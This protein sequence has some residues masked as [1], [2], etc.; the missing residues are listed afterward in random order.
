MKRIAVMLLVAALLTGVA[1]ADIQVY[2]GT[3]Y[4]AF[5][6]DPVPVGVN[7]A[8][9]KLI[10]FDLYFTNKTADVD[11]NP[12]TMD[13]QSDPLFTGITGAL[14]QQEG[15]ILG[16]VSETLSS[17]FAT[18]IDSHFLVLDTDL[19]VTTLPTEDFDVAVSVEPTDVVGPLAPFA[20]LSF[21]SYMGGSFTDT[22]TTGLTTRSLA[23]LVIV[24]PG[25][26][27]VGVAYEAAGPAEFSLVDNFYLMTG[28]GGGEDVQFGIGVI[29]EPATMSLLAIGGVVALIRR[30]K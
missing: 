30:R 14:H 15:P 1:S 12:D 3:T 2:T 25:Q 20:A 6:T 23:H 22:T 27:L 13:D 26:P 7:P 19:I 11:V 5:I 21:G 28:S 10:G 24:D 16:D 9:E 18:A 17:S 8:G 29:P 4:D